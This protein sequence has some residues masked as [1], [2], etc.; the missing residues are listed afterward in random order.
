MDGEVIWNGREIRIE[1]KRCVQGRRAD[2]E[3]GGIIERTNGRHTRKIA[4]HIRGTGSMSE[5]SQ[6]NAR[7]LKTS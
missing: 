2:A 5:S 6:V 4:G 7:Q 3:V 1:Q